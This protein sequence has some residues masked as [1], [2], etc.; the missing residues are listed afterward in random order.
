MRDRTR[1]P[2]I[3]IVDNCGAHGELNDEQVTFFPLPPNVTSLHQPLDSGIIAALERRYQGRLLG[4]FIGAFERFRLRSGAWSQAPTRASDPCGARGA[5]AG[6]ER[7]VVRSYEAGG[8]ESGGPARGTVNLTG[9][10]RCGPGAASFADSVSWNRDISAFCVTGGAPRPTIQIAKT[11]S[12]AASAQGGTSTG[13]V[14]A[15]LVA[16]PTG[17]KMAPIDEPQAV[18]GFGAAF[19][20]T[21][22]AEP[23]WA[24][25]RSATRAMEF[26]SRPGPTTAISSGPNA[27]RPLEALAGGEQPGRV[28]EFAIE[29]DIGPDIGAAG[30]TPGGVGPRRRSGPLISSAGVRTGAPD[31]THPPA[32]G[33]QAIC[34]VDGKGI[35]MDWSIAAATALGASE[36]SVVAG[37]PSDETEG[38][39]A[40][41]AA[42][43]ATS[44]TPPSV[45]GL[46]PD[47]LPCEPSVSVEPPPEKNSWRPDAGKQRQRASRMQAAAPRVVLGVCDGAQAHLQ[48]M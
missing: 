39:P 28:P 26:Q 4:L 27:S 14:G 35:S 41:P 23:S 24:A 22:G 47:P 7:R 11:R 42:G 32:A 46:E 44:Y 21:L 40:P 19:G 34:T 45:L 1:L 6:S 36:T 3:L 15:N 38:A 43:A 25:V 9:A 31:G 10:T 37:R 48:D 5:A 18:L 8:A 33:A 12:L 2:C 20:G 29:A 30:W 16:A 17:S 13:Q